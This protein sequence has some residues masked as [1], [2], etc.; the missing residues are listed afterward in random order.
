[1]EVRASEAARRI[2]VHNGRCLGQA[3]AD[4]LYSFGLQYPVT[5]PDDVPLRIELPSDE[6]YTGQLVSATAFEVTLACGVRLPEKLASANLTLDTSF[7]L[8]QL[9]LRLADLEPEDCDL[10]MA[11]FGFRQPLVGAPAPAL[12]DAAANEFQLEALAAVLA[13]DITYVWGPPGTGKTTALALIA[14]ALVQRGLRVL[15]VASTNVAVDN[16]VLKVAERVRGEGKVIRLGT[17]QL[18]ALRDPLMPALHSRGSLM[19]TMPLPF[20]VPI[21]APKENEPEAG[22]GSVVVLPAKRLPDSQDEAARQRSL[23]QARLV[24]ATLS[25]IALAPEL[26]APGFDAVLL[27]EASAAQL[28]AAFVV[29]ALARTKVVALGDP[30][31]LPPVA[32]SNGPLSRRWLQRDVFAQAG[33]DDED[34]RAVLLREQYRMPAA[35][36][37]LAN[38]LVYGGKLV[39]APGLRH[40]AGGARLVDTSAEGSHCERRDGSRLNRV[41]AELAVQLAAELVGQHHG[42]KTVAVIAPYRAQARLIWRLLRDARLDRS[43][44]VGTVHRFQGLER[45]AVVFDTVEAPPERPAPFVSGGYGSEAMRLINVAITRAQSDLIVIANVAHL[46]RMLPRNATLRGLLELLA[47][48]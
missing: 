35:V 40:R 17:P 13:R 21:P 7:I 12:D 46:S 48:D 36:S 45:R 29:A 16:A 10:P 31:Q 23:R 38:E 9:I 22:M 2:P 28:P 34:A 30:K 42:D 14:E 37:R 4:W 19:Q 1:V 47:G 41:H 11:L 33:L 32:L 26:A 8:E 39:D 18:P 43:V 5:L 3:G 24:G 44:D 6:T 25:R 20:D 27:D 15:A